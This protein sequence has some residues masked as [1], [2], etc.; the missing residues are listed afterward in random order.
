[1]IDKLDSMLPHCSGTGA[2]GRS[3]DHEFASV[4][5]SAKSLLVLHFQKVVGSAGVVG[6]CLGPFQ[7]GSST[8]NAASL[9]LYCMCRSAF[10][11]ARVCLFPQ[12]TSPTY[13]SL[14][15]N[16]KFQVSEARGCCTQHR[17]P[18]EAHRSC[19]RKLFSF[20]RGLSKK[21]A[22]R[23]DCTSSLGAPRPRR[24]IIAA[25]RGDIRSPTFKFNIWARVHARELSHCCHGKNGDRAA[26]AA[27]IS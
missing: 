7:P 18:S 23:R 13:C 25:S 15:D 17:S 10:H 8:K 20:Q 22:L 5:L 14:S 1:M 9:A 12:P 6:R 3:G 21:P 4:C 19:K 2:P 11:G 26:Q 24:A 27:P 16:E